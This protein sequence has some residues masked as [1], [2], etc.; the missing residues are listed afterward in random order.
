MYFDKGGI[1]ILRID[2]REDHLARKSLFG[3]TRSQRLAVL[4]TAS[5]IA[6]CAAHPVFAQTADQPAEAAESDHRERL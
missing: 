2:I 5:S 1:H 4:T 6:L 3:A